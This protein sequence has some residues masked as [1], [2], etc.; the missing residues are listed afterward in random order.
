[1]NNKSPVSI[2]KAL[3][4]LLILITLISSLTLYMIS[5]HLNRVSIN[6]VSAKEAQNQTR[7]VFLN[8]YSIMTQGGTR[9]GI[10]H[11]L[12]LINDSFP[13]MNVRVIRSEKLDQQYGKMDDSAKF[14]TQDND[15]ISVFKNGQELFIYQENA[16][17][18]IYP[19]KVEQECMACHVNVQ[20]GDLN[21]VIDILYPN[22]LLK[23]SLDNTLH[24]TILIVAAFFILLFIILYIALYVMFIRPIMDLSSHMKDLRESHFSGS[25]LEHKRNWVMEINELT[26]DYNELLQHLQEAQQV[27]YEQ[28]IQDDLT[29]LYNRRKFDSEIAIELHRSKRYQHSFVILILDLNQFKPINDNFGHQAGDLLL[30][31]FA[32]MLSLQVR[33]QDL[34]A[35]IGG[36]EFAIILP[37]TRL[38]S[39]EIA[40][41]R[42]QQALTKLE[43]SYDDNNLSVGVSIGSAC[44]PEDGDDAAKLLA[45]ADKKMYKNKAAS[46]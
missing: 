42:I 17:R 12:D 6:E 16:L 29:G 44:Y 32:K 5:K 30:K 45:V 40:V 39:A 43:V 11:A 3:T 14:R 15:V 25:K 37:E 1:M 38:D 33:E 2:S 41:A 23:E 18:F 35:R 8:L 34:V 28:S 31:A 36:D 46:R 9:D 19:I 21:G 26:N 24:K 13:Q 22:T 10:K 27:I 4:V 7:L 20:P